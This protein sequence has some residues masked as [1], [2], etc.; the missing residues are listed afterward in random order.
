MTEPWCSINNVG[1]VERVRVMCLAS[2]CGA[3]FFCRNPGSGAGWAL[4]RSLV[5]GRSPAERGLWAGPPAAAN[6]SWYGAGPSAILA[7]SGA[8]RAHRSAAD[9]IAC[10]RS[11]NPACSAVASGR[12]WCP[13]TRLPTHLSARRRWAKAPRPAAVSA[14]AGPGLLGVVR[15]RRRRL[16]SLTAREGPWP[17]RRQLRYGERGVPL[18]RVP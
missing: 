14:E 11:S 16:L 15:S 1:I 5:A 13:R 12:A 17:R 9:L 18:R 3:N 8:G 7:N 6:R 2:R 10:V 4:Q